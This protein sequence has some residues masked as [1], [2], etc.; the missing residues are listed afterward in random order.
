LRMRMVITSAAADRENRIF[1][2]Y[3]GAGR[4]YR[5][6]EGQ[7]A[8]QRAR[9]GNWF[10]AIEEP[11]QH[12]AATLKAI[13]GGARNIKVNGV[14]EKPATLRRGRLGDPAVL[15]EHVSVPLGERG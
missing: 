2:A 10:L 3:A 7:F 6:G 5:G 9:R 8:R 12:A 13:V 15:A 14:A 4:E 11:A 1:D